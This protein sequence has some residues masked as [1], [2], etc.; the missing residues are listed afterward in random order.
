MMNPEIKR[1]V[2]TQ[3][4]AGLRIDLVIA[5]RLTNLS[6]NQIQKLLDTGHVLVNKKQVRRANQMASGDQVEI[7]ISKQQTKIL[8]DKNIALEILYAGPDVLAINK[9]AGLVVHPGAGRP[10]HSLVNALL[11]H[12][13]DIS[14]IGGPSRPGVVHRLDM[15]TSGVLLIARS[16]RGYQSLVEQFS[17]RQVKKIYV[18]LVEGRFPHNSGMIEAPIRRSTT[19]RRRMNIDWTGKQAVSK[20]RTLNRGEHATLLEV[21]LITG[22]THQARVH[23]A[24]VGHPVLGDIIYGNA[25]AC[26]VPR[27]MLHAW[28]ISVTLPTTE[29]L[30]VRSG[31]HDDMAQMI[32]DNGLGKDTEIYSGSS[33]QLSAPEQPSIDPK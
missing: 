31:L 23:L 1:F 22:R 11:A 33:W 15:N 13:P 18:A 2:A 21:R 26:S 32:T 10:D 16:E 25:K 24:S 30:K 17:Q 12:Y 27:H 6:R 8:P 7:T 28:E 19:D 14:T 20:F 3:A 29:T 4:E 9:P 5:G